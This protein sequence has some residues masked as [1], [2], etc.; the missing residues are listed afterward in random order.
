MVEDFMFLSLEIMLAVICIAI[1]ALILVTI[2]VLFETVFENLVYKHKER[3]LKIQDEK[4]R[5]DLERKTL[6]KSTEF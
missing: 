2:A 3:K 5:L 4:Q 1:S 6:E